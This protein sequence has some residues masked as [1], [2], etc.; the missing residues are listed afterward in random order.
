MSSCV[1]IWT[2]LVTNSETLSQYEYDSWDIPFCNYLSYRHDLDMHAEHI[3][4]I[5][6]S[7]WNV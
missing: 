3:K 4:P 6:A 7:F 1:A 5:H 2:S